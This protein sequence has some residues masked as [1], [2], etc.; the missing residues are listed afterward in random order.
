V[1]R[2]VRGHIVSGGGGARKRHELVVVKSNASI[3]KRGRGGRGM[4]GRGGRGSRGRAGRGGRG[5]RGGRA[6]FGSGAPRP[7]PNPN[8]FGRRNDDGSVVV[9]HGGVEVVT[10]SKGGEVREFLCWSCC[11]PLSPV[12]PRSFL[13]E[14]GYWRAMVRGHTYMHQRCAGCDAWSQAERTGRY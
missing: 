3:S 12:I 11:S 9:V 6:G 10:V 5:G 4:R 1:A 8:L 13:G 14:T 7:E 2:R